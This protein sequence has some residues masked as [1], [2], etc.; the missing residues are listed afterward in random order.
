MSRSL[1]MLK[2]LD[3]AKKLE[4]SDLQADGVVAQNALAE[5]DFFSRK[6]LE[7]R[8][9]TRQ[10]YRQLEKTREWAENN[11]YHLPIDQQDASLIT[12]NSFWND[13]AAHD[14]KQPFL[15]RNL[16]DASRSFPEILLA[17]AVLDL[18]FEAPNTESK[19]DESQMTLVPGG[20]IVVFHQEIR[21]ADA[22]DDNAK[23]LVTQNYFKYG[24]RERVVNGEKVDVFVTGEFL[25]QTVYGCQ[26]VITNPTSTRQKVN[27]L[28]QNPARSDSCA[29][30][31]THPDNPHDPGTLS[32]ADSGISL[33]LPS[34]RRIRSLSPFT[35]PGTN[36]CWPPPPPDALDVVA[37]PTNVDK[38][39]WD[40]VSQHGSLDE[41]VHV[42]AATQHRGSP[43]WNALPGGCR[44][45]RRSSR[46]S[47]CLPNDTSTTTHSGP[48]L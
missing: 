26:V 1:G 36:R 15:S 40:Y 38:E 20:P 33:L 7:Q 8:K 28:I 25:I 27:V 5:Q 39:S 29:G 3:E 46:S 31:Q 14:P 18:P 43:T 4:I 24:E 16:A 44:T 30:W 47:R 9:R 6:D 37:Q 13:F 10:L 19:F 11:Y 45:K 34:T 21:P 22:P 23:L 41:V 12:V 2:S 32:H 17:L 42:F 35:S 48:T